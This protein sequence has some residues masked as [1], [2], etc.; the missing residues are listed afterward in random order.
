[1]ISP[2]WF[3]Y[4]NTVLSTELAHSC[5]QA[6][7]SFVDGA[8]VCHS[9]GWSLTNDR[10][11]RTRTFVNANKLVYRGTAVEYAAFHDGEHEKAQL[12]RSRKRANKLVLKAC[13]YLV[14][15]PWV[16]QVDL[17]PIELL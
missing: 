17:M 7:D 5:D 16:L 12:V 9:S 10:H 11:E 15:L 13:V 4:H 8:A 1:M 14:E 2:V 3:W 6:G